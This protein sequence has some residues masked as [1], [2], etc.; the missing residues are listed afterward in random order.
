MLSNFR[1]IQVID[2][3]QI[4]SIN[5]G[6]THEKDLTFLKR[7][8]NRTF[9]TPATTADNSNTNN[10]PMKPCRYGLNCSRVD[11]HFTHPDR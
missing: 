3:P 6:L 4:L 5:C 8:I 2:L 11:C 1:F 9:T 10:P 7:Q